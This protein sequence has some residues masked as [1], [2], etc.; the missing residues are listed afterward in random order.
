MRASMR[1]GPVRDV[2]RRGV[3]ISTISHS[4]HRFYQSSGGKIDEALDDL[5][6]GV[7]FSCAL[8]GQGSCL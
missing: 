3:L 7:M 2:Q 1:S 6:V 5:T 4:V 8:G